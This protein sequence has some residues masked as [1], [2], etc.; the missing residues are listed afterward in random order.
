MRQ[1]SVIRRLDR[2]ISRPD[3]FNRN[4]TPMRHI[5]PLLSTL[6]PAALAL[7]SCAQIPPIPAPEDEIVFRSEGLAPATKAA[8][9][10]AL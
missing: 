9:V 8:Q 10:T 6:L 2:R 7:L 4:L 1:F 3:T 5:H